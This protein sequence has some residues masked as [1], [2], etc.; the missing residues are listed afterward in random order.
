MENRKRIAVIVSNMRVA[1]G[2]TMVAN[3]LPYVDAK[4]FDILLVVLEKERVNKL[5][6][7][8]S[9][10]H[11]SSV[12]LGF[13]ASRKNNYKKFAK[14]MKSFNPDLVHVNLDRRYSYLW[15]FLHKKPLILTLHSEPARYFKKSVAF[16]ARLVVLRHKLTI[17]GVSK[18]ISK[19]I[20]SA[21]KIDPKNIDTI[22]NPVQIPALH[23]IDSSNEQKTQLVCVARL[24]PV[25]NHSLLLKV[26]AKVLKSFPQTVLTLAGS[27]PLEKELKKLAKDLDILD[28]VNFLGNVDDINHLLQQSDVFVLSSKSEA[29]PISILEAMAN[30]LPIIAPRVGGIPEL[31]TNET[32]ILYTVNSEENLFDALLTILV[33]KQ[34]RKELGKNART[35]VT[36]FTP[37]NIAREYERIYS[38]IH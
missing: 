27:G 29:L 20:P 9:D 37:E 25:K 14:Q 24:E 33:K 38:T 13:N 1:G 23:K 26:F 35:F 16:L 7:K 11:I 12:F 15:C 21:F 3:L 31:V 32:G 6:K 30:G 28:N 18:E 8:L 4:Y 22:Y 2:Q 34:M 5:T 36:Q 19:A 10:A 17:V